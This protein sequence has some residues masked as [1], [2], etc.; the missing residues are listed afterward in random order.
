MEIRKVVLVLAFL[1]ALSSLARGTIAATPLAYWKFN[2]GSGT[3][4]ADSSG[5]GNNA[6]FT[7]SA[8]AVW[9]WNSTTGCK[10]GRCVQLDKTASYLLVS[11]GAALNIGGD[12]TI[13]TWVKFRN[14]TENQYIAQSSTYWL[15]NR[16]GWA[17]QYTYFCYH[18]TDTAYVGDSS[19]NNWACAREST[20]LQADKWY[21]ITGVKSGNILKMYVNGTLERSVD[22]TG[23]VISTSGYSG[24]SIGRIGGSGFNGT[25]D[26]LKIYNTALSD[27]EVLSEY[28]SASLV[29]YWN[30]DDGS[31][32]TAADST[33]NGNTGN[34]ANGTSG[35][36]VC[37]AKACP[38]WVAGIHGNALQFDGIGDYV[39]I[40]ENPTLRMASGVTM[41]TWIK[42]PTIATGKG[43]I[44]G[45]EGD[46]YWEQGYDLIY[47]NSVNR[48]QMRLGYGDGA[49][50]SLGKQTY[51]NYT[52]NLKDD[53]WHHVAGVFN[54]SNTYLYL[55]GI[56]VSSG[57]DN[58]DISN[59]V[60][61][62]NIG[63]EGITPAYMNSPFNGTIDEVKLYGSAL[64]AADVLADYQGIPTTTTTTTTTVPS[65]TTTVA[66]TTT[67]TVPTTTTTATPTTTLPHTIRF[68]SFSFLTKTNQLNVNWVD[69]YS[70]GISVSVKCTLNDAQVCNPF[71]Y[72]GPAGGGGCTI[73]TPAYNTAPAPGG[74]HTVANKLNCTAYD[75]AQPS[76]KYENIVNFYPRALEV[77]VPST[78]SPTLGEQENL[79]ITIKNNG[80]LT[81][82]YSVSVTPTSPNMLTVTGG[83]QTTESLNNN[84]IQQMYAKLTLLVSR[85]STTAN[86]VVSSV[87]QPSI[88]FSVPV[89]VRGTDRSLPDFDVY[90]LV[91]LVLLTAV[92]ASFLF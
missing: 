4:A 52:V 26:D 34:L 43:G 86:V 18:I 66:P 76:T 54:K 40:A 28:K 49:T 78:M 80:T 31:G 38:S 48:L 42:I 45:C 69:E 71:P 50:A 89:S 27:S 10:L 72:T 90:G 79:L 58:N 75:T 12:M 29:A 92:L 55:D 57:T 91:Q 39:M 56:L 3:T 11:P 32:T 13:T 74:L 2:E 7:P 85:Q 23:H 67:T 81:D 20:T 5:G 44:I 88:Q 22:I 24:L 14:F 36:G 62:C 15:F 47:D 64:S 1:V 6:V 33:G 87:S 53:Q 41:E 68:T 60:T 61:N 46:N 63:A 59:R 21:Y 35:T 30:L 9:D 19:W 51:L 82:T 17:G 73:T 8:P 25:I 77:G 16:N 70:G 65:T 83:S 37:G 84:D